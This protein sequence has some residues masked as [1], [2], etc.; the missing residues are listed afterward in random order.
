MGVSLDTNLSMEKIL[1]CT[2][3]LG[4]IWFRGNN[5]Q[6]RPTKRGQEG[7]RCPEADFAG[8]KSHRPACFCLG[9]TNSFQ[10]ERCLPTYAVVLITIAGEQPRTRLRRHAFISLHQA[11]VHLRPLMTCCAHH[12]LS[13]CPG[14]VLSLALVIFGT[15]SNT[16]TG[17]ERFVQ[18]TVDP[19]DYWKV[20]LVFRPE[21]PKNAEHWVL[22]SESISATGTDRGLECAVVGV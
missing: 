14:F 17:Q 12:G 2:T 8:S 11:V 21:T 10:C 20:R 18:Q 3:L 16:A 22:L 13:A 19:S 7:E 4:Y 1:S 6:Q 9:F 15:F 5:Q